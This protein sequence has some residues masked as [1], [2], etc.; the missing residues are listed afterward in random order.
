MD[1]KT[2]KLKIITDIRSPNFAE[3]G[4][5]DQIKFIIIHATECDFDLT[6]RILTDDAAPSRVSAHYVIDQDGT[7][8]QLVDD[9]KIAWHAGVSDWGDYRN[10]NSYSIGIELVQPDASYQTPYP[11][12]QLQAAQLLVRDLMDR[13]NVV[14]DHILGHCH[15][16]PDRKKDPG[17]LFPWEDFRKGL[18]Q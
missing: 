18:H 13:H 12:V 5:E 8:H 11:E 3:R 17:P 16:A 1:S 4:P 10:L 7:T 9:D 6:M 14:V 2:S 15:V